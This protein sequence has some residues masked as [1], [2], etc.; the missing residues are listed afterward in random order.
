MKKRKEKR[1]YVARPGIEPKT[2][3]LRVRCPTDRATRPGYLSLCILIMIFPLLVSGIR[4]G[5][6]CWAGQEPA[7]L[8]L[9][10]N[11]P[12]IICMGSTVVVPL[13]GSLQL[14]DE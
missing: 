3:D 9:V 14:G 11:R 4:V 13:L 8:A 2:P 1:K 5:G 12:A 10:G 6:L 7:A